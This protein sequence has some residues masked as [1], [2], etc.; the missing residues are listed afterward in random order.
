MLY[1]KLFHW[2]SK[3]SNPFTKNK[4]FYYIYSSKVISFERITFTLYAI[5]I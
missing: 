4:N 1:C 3:I 5:V 2:N